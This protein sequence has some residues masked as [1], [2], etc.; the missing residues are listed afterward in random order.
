MPER[1]QYALLVYNRGRLK[2]HWRRHERDHPGRVDEASNH[3][4]KGS[5]DLPGLLAEL[6]KRYPDDTI[7]GVGEDEDTG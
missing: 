6:R 7:Y 1:K 3:R 4:E 5:D 2:W